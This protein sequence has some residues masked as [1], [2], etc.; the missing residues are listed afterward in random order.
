[1]VSAPNCDG[2]GNGKTGIM[3]TGG[4][5]NQNFVL[6]AGDYYFGNIMLS[7]RGVKQDS[8]TYLYWSSGTLVI[9]TR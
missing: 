3:A 2:I 9:I 5:I 7:I 1:M 6:H 8:L 4:V